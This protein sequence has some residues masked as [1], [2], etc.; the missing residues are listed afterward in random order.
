[1]IDVFKHPKRALSDRVIATPTLIGVTSE[2]ILTMIGDLTDHAKLDAMLK[3]LL[4]V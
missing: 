1:V 4:A 2:R 3:S